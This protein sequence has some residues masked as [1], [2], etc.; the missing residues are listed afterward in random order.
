MYTT[1]ARA[2]LRTCV[3]GFVQTLESP[4]IQMLRFPGLKNLEKGTGPGKHWKILG[5]L[6]YWS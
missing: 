1:F 5:I 3:T 2:I 4:K 6:K